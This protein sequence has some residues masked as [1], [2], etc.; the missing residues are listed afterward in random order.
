M[1]QLPSAS[2]GFA[3]AFALFQRGGAGN[4]ESPGLKPQN[5]KGD[6]D[7]VPEPAMRVGAGHE[8]FHVGRGG[9]GNVHVEKKGG[10]EKGGLVGK[11]ER[12]LHHDKK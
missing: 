8:Q 4:I 3:N 2:K 1:L 11:V 10:Q 7:V 5:G 6:T 9:E 12:V